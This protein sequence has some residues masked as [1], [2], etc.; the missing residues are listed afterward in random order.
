MCITTPDPITNDECATAIT[1]NVNTGLDCTVLNSGSITGATPTTVPL[2][3]CA[4][5]EDDDV[6]Y[7]FTANS[8]KQIITFSNIQG[9]STDIVH[10]LY[11]GTC[12][13]LT[14]LYCSDA[15]ES[16][17]ENLI[18]GDTYYIRVWSASNALQDITYD[19]CIIKVPP[20]IYSSSTAYNTVPPETFTV[21]DLVMDKLINVNEQC[22]TVTNITYRTGTAQGF[23]GIGYFNKGDS[24]FPMDEGVILST[25]TA[26]NAKAAQILQF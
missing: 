10:S 24:L 21:E 16:S 17:P 15:D 20:P 5:T 6:W 1:A 22:A 2:S 23:N 12:D 18:V 26:A 25:G 4:G 19:F 8:A 7:K 11:H 13:S 3:T 14:L 9:T